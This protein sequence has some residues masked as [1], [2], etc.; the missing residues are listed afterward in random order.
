MPS[1]RRRRASESN[2]FRPGRDVVMK[3]G[4]RIAAL[5]IGATL[6]VALP[7]QAQTPVRGGSLTYTYHPEPTTLSTIS[8]TAVPVA[9][10]ATKIYESLLQWEGAEMKPVPGLA[11]SWTRSEDGKTWTFKLRA[12]VKWH[13]GAPFTSE[14]VKF[15]IESIVRPYHSRGRASFGDVEAIETPDATTVIFRMK[16]PVPYFLKAFQSTETP[17]MPRH[18][19]QGIDLA[20][21]AAV[22]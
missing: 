20:Q 12:G 9:L 21:A 19:F 18:K 3:S 10:I 8:T 2:V 6:S 22:R 13:D 5:A 1:R 14:D 7:L 16:A 17:I 11:E 15:S 4:L